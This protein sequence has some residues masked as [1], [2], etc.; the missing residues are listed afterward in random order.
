MHLA[1]HPHVLHSPAHLIFLVLNIW[2]GFG[3]SRHSL[4]TI[5][6]E[7]HVFSTVPFCLFTY[8]L[9]NKSHSYRDISFQDAHRSVEVDSEDCTSRSD[10]LSLVSLPFFLAKKNP[11]QSAKVTTDTNPLIRGTKWQDWQH[12]K[13]KKSVFVKTSYQLTPAM[14]ISEPSPLVKSKARA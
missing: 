9:T 13:Q 2:I 1:C 5:L 10:V 12:D 11:F 14:W 4:R 6:A 3:K 8:L 7:C